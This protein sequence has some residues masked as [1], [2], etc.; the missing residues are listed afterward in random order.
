MQ[1]RPSPYAPDPEW[2]AQL[3]APVVLTQLA[4]LLPEA[5]FFG[6]DA[7]RRIAWWSPGAERL[8]GTPANAVVGTSCKAAQRCHNCLAGCGIGD[9]GEVRDVPLVVMGA[10]GQPKAVRK[11]GIAFHTASGQFAGG[12]EVL[13]PDPDPVAPQTVLTA[14]TVQFHG[15]VAHSVQMREVFALVERVGPT[16]ATVLLRGESGTGKEGIARALHQLSGRKGKFVAVNCAAL[17][18]GL[19]DS[20]LFGHVRGSFTGALRDH[21]GFFREADGGTLFLDEVAELPLDTQAKLLRVLQE[22]LVTPVGSTKSIAVDVRI[23]AATHRS[24]REQVSKGQFRED[25]LYRLRVVP[26][27]IPALRD[28]SGDLPVLLWHLIERK[29]AQGRRVI[30]QVESDAMK[31]LLQWRWPGNVRELQNAVEYVFAVGHG[32]VLR[33]VDLPSELRGMPIPG[34]PPAVATG[35]AALAEE[36][37][38]ALAARIQAALQTHKGHVGKAAESLGLSRPTFWRY[39]KRLGV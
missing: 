29:N 20:E 35:P 38:A 5:A 9:R 6:V 24:L 1:Q 2:L 25:L 31:L 15:L 32:P 4:R 11:T 7:D 10:D 13:L 16:D 18:T 27:H 39:R 8:L 19:L 21:N 17:A 30:R 34:T 14:E 26:I 37:D 36:G 22:R 12:I 3:G 28:R 23:V 33:A